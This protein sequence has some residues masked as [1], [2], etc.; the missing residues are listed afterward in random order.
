MVKGL[1]EGLKRLWCYA[2]HPWVQHEG[3]ATYYGVPGFGEGETRVNVTRYCK[4]CGR[5]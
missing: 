2:F 1:I 3:S 4:K 5:R